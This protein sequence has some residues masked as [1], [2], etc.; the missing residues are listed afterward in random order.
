L[1]QTDPDR[2]VEVSVL[3]GATAQG[4]PQLLKIVLENLVGNAWKYTR[5]MPVARIEFGAMERE[6]EH[7][8]FV[9]DNGAGFDMARREKLFL[10]FERLH[11][12]QDFPGN[13]VGLATVQRAIQRHGGEVW[14]EGEPEKGACFY[15]TLEARRGP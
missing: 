4:D 11:S 1:R 3:P 9:R 7:C 5:R 14:G 2:L 12:A 15:F 8:Y 13:G 10:P 6:G